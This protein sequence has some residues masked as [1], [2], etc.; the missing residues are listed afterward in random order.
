MSDEVIIQKFKCSNPD[1]SHGLVA[2]TIHRQG[3]SSIVILEECEN[4]KGTGIN[5]LTIII[6]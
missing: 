5:T 3:D 2:N 6:K 1:C 4:C